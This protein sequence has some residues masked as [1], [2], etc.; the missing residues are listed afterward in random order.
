MERL[1][2]VQDDASDWRI[3]LAAV[4]GVHERDARAHIPMLASTGIHEGTLL[5]SNR[6]G[7]SRFPGTICPCGGERLS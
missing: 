3:R 4:R 5:R 1:K 7:V 6:S 2:A